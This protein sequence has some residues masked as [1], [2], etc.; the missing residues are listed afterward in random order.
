MGKCAERAGRNAVCVSIG[1]SYRHGASERANKATR[2]WDVI[3]CRRAGPA[4]VAG[5]KMMQGVAV[6]R[7]TMGFKIGVV[8][9]T[10][11]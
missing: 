11:S 1:V 5:F 9:G 4:Q 8:G 7:R 2:A 10:C 6:K 3:N